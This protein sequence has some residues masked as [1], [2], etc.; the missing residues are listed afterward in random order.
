MALK[1]IKKKYR[2]YTIYIKGDGKYSYSFKV[3]K[4]KAAVYPSGA[5]EWNFVP[6]SSF[7]GAYKE[8]IRMLDWSWLSREHGRK[9]YQ[10]LRANLDQLI[11]SIYPSERDKKQFI[12]MRKYLDRRRN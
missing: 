8:V 9:I 12:K 7:G 3:M 11:V 5:D 1:V 6:A 4:G 10:R 2:A